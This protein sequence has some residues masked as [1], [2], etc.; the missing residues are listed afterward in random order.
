MKVQSQ[1]EA[2]YHNG[3][4]YDRVFN[5]LGVASAS[6]EVYLVMYH[7][8]HDYVSHQMYYIRFEPIVPR[9]HKRQTFCANHTLHI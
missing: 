2:V 8:I 6:R 4:L 3:Y 7:L 1:S 9:Q 5:T